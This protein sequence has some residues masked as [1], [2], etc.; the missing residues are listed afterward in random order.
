MN[1]TEFHSAL[2][3]N[4]KLRLKHGTAPMLAVSYKEDDQVEVDVW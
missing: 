4:K 3:F 2:L 1:L